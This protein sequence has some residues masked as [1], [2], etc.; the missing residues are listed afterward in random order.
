ML[1]NAPTHEGGHSLDECSKRKRLKAKAVK[2]AGGV[3]ELNASS[4]VNNLE[5]L[6]TIQRGERPDQS[7]IER[8]ADLDY[9]SVRDVTNHDTP[10]GQREYLVISITEKGRRLLESSRKP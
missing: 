9:I 5:A 8:L 1:R 4:P 7:T 2:T 10:P 3:W 6:K